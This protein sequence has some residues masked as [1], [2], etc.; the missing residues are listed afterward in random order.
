MRT[1]QRMIQQKQITVNFC[2]FVDLF[3]GN[4]KKAENFQI[5]LKSNN[6]F[7]WIFRR[8]DWQF[9]K[10]LKNIER[11]YFFRKENLK[12]VQEYLK[13]HERNSM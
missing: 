4:S 5:I 8:K 1:K 10:I 2:G 3:P 11:P 12:T 9:K 6:L 7:R 13:A